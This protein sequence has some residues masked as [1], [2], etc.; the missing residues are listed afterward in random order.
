VAGAFLGAPP[1]ITT[2][3]RRERANISAPLRPA[4]P[5]SITTA[6]TVSSG[7]LS[8]ALAIIVPDMSS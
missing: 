8:L 1:S 4:A 5:P 2:T 7:S 6:S 3:D